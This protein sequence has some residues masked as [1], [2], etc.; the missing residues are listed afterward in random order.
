M[1]RFLGRG[2]LGRAGLALLLAAGGG[3]APALASE[4]FQLAQG[5]RS[6]LHRAA[7]TL[8]DEDVSI[9]FIAHSSYLL[10][11]AEGLQIATDW[12]GHFTH[13]LDRAPDVITMNHAHDT[14][15]TASPDPE[16][17]H[18]L[19][20][21]GVEG[22]PRRHFMRL[23]ETLIRNVPTDIRGGYTG[24][25]PFGNSIFIFEIGD[26]C[27]GHLGHIHHIPTEEQYALL[28]RLDVVMVPVDGRHTLGIEDI[29][30][31]LKRLKSQV[32]LPMHAFGRYTLSE[33]LT[34]MGEDFAVD[35]M[36]G[37]TLTLSQDR[38]PELPT[39]FVPESL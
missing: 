8:A 7:M 38:L 3:G 35:R 31:M 22:K 2:F 18:V 32:V 16:I 19:K 17:E 33:F 9:R 14:H 11:N 28:G 24:D 30:V 37:D 26:L 6:L 29:V 34:R 1:R 13:R 36:E 5:E 39:V 21:W 10:E 23:G 15:W 4:C 25:E 27:V 12:S 20:G